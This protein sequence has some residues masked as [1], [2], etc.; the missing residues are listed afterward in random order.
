M[1]SLVRQTFEAL[2]A[3]VMRMIMTAAAPDL[4]EEDNHGL[5]GRRNPSLTVCSN[6]GRERQRM[7][8]VRQISG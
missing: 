1:H 6:L 7:S 2:M 4:K 3:I 5:R 8:F